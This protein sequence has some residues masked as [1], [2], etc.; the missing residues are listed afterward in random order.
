[1]QSLGGSRWI[2]AAGANRYFD[3]LPVPLWNTADQAGN[4]ILTRREP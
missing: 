1:V 2:H 3:M 4:I